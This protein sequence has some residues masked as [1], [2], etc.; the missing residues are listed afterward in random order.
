MSVP[1]F[2]DALPHGSVLIASQDVWE[3][4]AYTN[5]LCMAFCRI[6]R[7]KQSDI[8]RAAQLDFDWCGENWSDAKWV[9]KKICQFRNQIKRAAVRGV[10]AFTICRPTNLY[11]ESSIPALHKLR[12]LA[13]EQ[14]VSIIIV[15]QE[16]RQWAWSEVKV[17]PFNA[18]RYGKKLE[19]IVDAGGV[20]TLAANNTYA[21]VFKGTGGLVCVFKNIISPW[22]V[23]Y[24]AFPAPSSEAQTMDAFPTG[25]QPQS[26]VVPK[27]LPTRGLGC[28]ALLMLCVI[29]VFLA[30]GL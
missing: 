25:A 1:D 9:S 10:I 4:D 6:L 2:L 16:K 3:G 27:A 12:K 26:L 20:L 13:V 29:C 21:V 17:N 24:T 23:D 28:I 19:S 8:T 11:P 22:S 5:Q 18:I 30:W 14:G 15:T 7:Q